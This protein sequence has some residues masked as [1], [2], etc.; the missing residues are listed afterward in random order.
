MAPPAKAGNISSATGRGRR[1]PGA[2]PA[3]S[4]GVQV[5]S[6]EFA[7]VGDDEPA[8]SIEER[9]VLVDLGAVDREPALDDLDRP[10]EIPALQGRRVRLEDQPAAR[11]GGVRDTGRSSPRGP[12]GCCRRRCGDSR[13]TGR[14][15]TVRRDRRSPRTRRRGTRRWSSRDTRRRSP[16]LDQ[17]RVDLERDDAAGRV[18]DREGQESAVRTDLEHR[19]VAARGRAIRR[20]PRGPWCRA[21]R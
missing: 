19:A 9:A 2:H 13:T 20:P 5:G 8:V 16:R 3:R 10:G 12:D 18:G 21:V 11:A 17:V 14:R 7:P 4:G 15:R 6:G 1:G